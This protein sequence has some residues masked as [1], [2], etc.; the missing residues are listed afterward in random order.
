MKSNNK[1]QAPR[2][3]NLENYR[4][5]KNLSAKNWADQL[6]KRSLLAIENSVEI[7]EI[8]LFLKHIESN[9]IVPGGGNYH[10]ATDSTITNTNCSN[11]NDKSKLVQ[12]S[13]STL[14]CEN[15]FYFAEELAEIKEEIDEGNQKFCNLP[16]DEYFQQKGIIGEG[17]I[18]LTINLN[19][20]DDILKQE[21]KSILEATRDQY[22]YLEGGR[23]SKNILT[24]LYQSRVIPYI[25]LTIWINF[26]GLNVPYHALGGWLFPDEEVDISEKIR[27]VTKPWRARATSNDFIVTIASMEK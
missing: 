11:S 25:D 6:N 8:E 13:V 19:A 4:C 7:G 27:K 21:F 23:I 2:W 20:P 18:N 5:F 12:K 9:P 22:Q 17:L 24:H 1:H 16:I 10:G 14:T 3:F 15:A 26:K